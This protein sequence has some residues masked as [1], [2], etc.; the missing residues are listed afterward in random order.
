MY[1][2]CKH[3]S[4]EKHSGNL[5]KY[6]GIRKN[7]TT[8]SHKVLTPTKTVHLSDYRLKR[9]LVAIEK[10]YRKE[11]KI[12]KNITVIGVQEPMWR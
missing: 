10:K 9:L 4:T 6:E 3:K 11:G 7:D 12:L 2:R 8:L 5:G 1:I